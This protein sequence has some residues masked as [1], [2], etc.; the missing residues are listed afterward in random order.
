MRKQ[1]LTIV[2]VLAISA[3]PSLRAQGSF[4]TPEKINDNWKFILN[5]VKDGQSVALDDSK[6]QSY[7]CPT[8]GA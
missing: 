5:D 7:R 1:L 6:W 2:M 4:G 3:V 8:T